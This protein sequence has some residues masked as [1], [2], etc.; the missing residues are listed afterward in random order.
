[1][2]LVEDHR[3]SRRDLLK[4]GIALALSSCAPYVVEEDYTQNGTRGL[5]AD[6][7]PP[8]RS[9]VLIEAS[10]P[11]NKPKEKLSP[12][13]MVP[14]HSYTSDFR[15]SEPYRIHNIRAGSNTLNNWFW[16][17]DGSLNANGELN[18]KG[19][20]LILPG[21]SFSLGEI[22]EKA[23]YVKGLAQGPNLLSIEVDGGGICQISSTLNA[24]ALRSGLQIDERKNHS[25][26]NGWYLGD[27]MDP[28]EL[29]IDATIFIP[30]QDWVI[31]NT[32]S[33]PIR[34]L[35]LEKDQ[36]LTAQIYTSADFVP[37]HVEIV[38]P[39]MTWPNYF[40]GVEVK[41][42]SPKEVVRDLG[43][44]FI[45]A[46]GTTVTQRVYIPGK[47]SMS[48]FLFEDKFQSTYQPSPY[49]LP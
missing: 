47:W 14:V 40:D 8:Q 12:E 24:L 7:N 42:R 17:F 22:I 11:L 27:K 25:Y 46:C 5:R 31:T 30:G 45:Y 26:Y 33:Y 21:E 1:M 39:T 18:K 48:L 13:I 9:T 20:N 19:K 15:G 49:P 32:F 34:F 37:F 35:L 38:G 36:R 3:L 2:S 29:G 41:G 44:P 16:E 10:T 28:K 43:R 6:P 4:S 23:D